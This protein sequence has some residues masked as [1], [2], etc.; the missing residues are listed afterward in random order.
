M[1][2]R[3]LWLGLFLV[4]TSGCRHATQSPVFYQTDFNTSSMDDWVVET[5]NGSVQV[6]QGD[7]DIN[8]SEGCTVWYKQ[9]LNAPVRIEFNVTI[10]D[11]N[12]PNDR[13]SDL[14]CFW[15]AIDPE[16]PD[17][18]FANHAKRTGAFNNYHPF[19]LYYVGMGG[20]S[21]TSTRFR[22]YPGT[23]ERPLLPEHDL[24]DVSV[25]LTANERVK[26]TIDS[27]DQGT[28]YF[29]D[30]KCLF[31]LKDEQPFTS[32][33]FGFRTVHNHMRIHSFKVTKL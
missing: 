1:K 25:L 3:V 17:D 13:V 30:G 6:D 5:V 11:A 7:L 16:H 29:R 2:H 12:E 22:R 20:N 24:S 33:W 26:I 23:G 21:N 28:R 31:D 10:V 9:K 15:M 27:T 32:G 18:I 8:V 19:R 4:W 14:N